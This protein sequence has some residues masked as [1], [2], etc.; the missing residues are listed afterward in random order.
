[1]SNY[2]SL[3][4]ILRSINIHIYS[5]KKKP[6][7]INWLFI[8]W[9]MIIKYLDN[10]TFSIFINYHLHKDWHQIKHHTF[11]NFCLTTM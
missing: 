9:A 10:K 2:I 3:E 1:M 8:I 7:Q 11:Q 5:G 4:Y 6:I